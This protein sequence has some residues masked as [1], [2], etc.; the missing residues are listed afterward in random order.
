MKQLIFET[1]TEKACLALLENKQIVAIEYFFGGPGLSEKL[2][3]ATAELLARHD[4]S[5]EQI[6]VGIGPGSFTG[7]RVGCSLALSLAF[8]WKIPLYTACSLRAFAPATLEPFAVLIDARSAG[9]YVQLA[10]SKPFLLPPDG[11]LPGITHLASPHPEKIQR[12][13]NPPEI[14]WHETSPS[15]HLLAQNCS[16]HDLSTPLSPYYLS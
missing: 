14:L 7:I 2:A 11:T 9:F 4:F 3:P 15:P 13:F 8:A 16:L 10:E 6:V 1:S 5:P 12:R